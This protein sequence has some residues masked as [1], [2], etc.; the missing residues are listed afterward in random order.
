MLYPRQPKGGKNRRILFVLDKCF[1]CL[2]HSLLV[3]VL[4][5]F[6]ITGAIDT[7]TSYKINQRLCQ[8]TSWFPT[9]TVGKSPEKNNATTYCNTSSLQ[10]YLRQK[11]FLQIIPTGILQSSFESIYIFIIHNTLCQGDTRSVPN[12]VLNL[13][14][15]SFI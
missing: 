5:D 10:D 2:L 8:Y 6:G 12:C 14:A 15:D 1:H 4:V 3:D 11:C 13:T 9:S 7:K